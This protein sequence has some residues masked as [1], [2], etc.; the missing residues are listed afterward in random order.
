MSIFAGLI[1]HYWQ[2]RL[3]RNTSSGI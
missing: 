3:E 2:Q 1:S